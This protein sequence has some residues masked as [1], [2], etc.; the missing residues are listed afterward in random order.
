MSVN[1]SGKESIES[2]T[3]LL[4]E[5]DKKIKDNINDT[6]QKN[7]DY[8]DNNLIFLKNDKVSKSDITNNIFPKGT[9]LYADLPTAEESIKGWYYYCTDGDGINGC[10]NYIC[11]GVDW[12]FGGNGEKGYY[13]LNDRIDEIGFYHLNEF[14][15]TNIT[16]GKY[17]NSSIGQSINTFVTKENSFVCNQ[18]WKVKKGDVIRCTWEWASF[19]VYDGEGKLVEVLGGSGGKEFTITSETAATLVYYN[20]STSTSVNYIANFMFSINRPLKEIYTDYKEIGIKTYETDALNEKISNIESSDHVPYIILNFDNDMDSLD[21]NAVLLLDKY[22]FKGNVVGWNSQDVKMKLLSKGWDIGTYDNSPDI[23][24]D[25]SNINKTDETS[26]GLYE[27]YVETAK[28][29]QEAIRVFNPTA[30]CCRQNQWGTA[31]AKAVKNNGYKMARGYVKGD[32]YN[33]D[34][35]KSFPV[36]DSKD[37]YTGDAEEIKYLIG[38]SEGKSAI[39]I[40]LA[41]RVVNTTSEDRGY[42]V[43]KTDYEEVLSYIKQLSDEGKVKV[44]TYRELYALLYPEDAYENDYNRLLKM[45]IQ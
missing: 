37:F 32:Y 14:D 25:P 12:F 21:N 5:N 36:L 29:K 19:N 39:I 18:R 1:Y 22:G 7:L 28:G 6:I 4:L 17:P 31:L 26:L 23:L 15:K 11:N 45:N 44:V 41:H 30:W 10:G 33:L 27:T 40:L 42:D 13:L 43:L 8:T 38:N 34:Y 35:D 20:P 3:R 24:P 9:C 2:M 16:I